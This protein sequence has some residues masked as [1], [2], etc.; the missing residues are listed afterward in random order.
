MTQ[1]K[2]R[3]DWVT[4]LLLALMLAMPAWTVAQSD[5][6]PGLDLLQPTTL[7][8]LLLGTLIARSKLRPLAAQLLGLGYGAAWVALAS[9]SHLPRAAGAGELGEQLVAL[10][11]HIGIWTWSLIQNGVGKDNFMFLLALLVVAW[12]LGFLAAWNTFR[13]ARV[14]RAVLPAGLMILIDLYYY[15]G[16]LELTPFLF[17][18]FAFTLLYLV[19]VH[20]MLREREWRKAWLGYDDDVRGAFLRGGSIVTLV[21]VFAAWAVPKVVP[22]VQ[23]EDLWRQ[24]NRPIRSLEDSFGRMFS[25]LKGE[26]PALTNPFGKSLGF[27]GARELSDQV[28]MDVLVHKSNGSALA[29]YWRAGTYDVYT[30]DGWLGSQRETHVFR[31]SASP[32]STPYL[33]RANVKQTFTTYFK[34]ATL[35]LA[36]AQPV[37]FNRDAEAGVERLAIVAGGSLPAQAPGFVDPSFVYSIDRLQEG[38]AYEV[39]SSLSIADVTTLRAAGSSYPDWIAEHYLQLP[40]NFPQRV[41]DLALQIVTEAGATNAFDQATALERW[42]R[43]N[44]TYDEKIEGPAQGQD[45]VDYVLFESHAGY[46][47]YYA[48]AMVT[49]ARSLG[50]PARLAVGYA[51][52]EFDA[53]SG[54]YRVR[55]RDAHSWVEIYFPNYG[56][57]EFEPTAAQPLISRPIVVEDGTGDADLSPVPELDPAERLSRLGEEE[58]VEPPPS[59]VSPLQQLTRTLPGSVIALLGVLLGVG[60]VFAVVGVYVFENRGLRGLRGARWAFARLVRLATWLRI[61]VRSHQTPYEQAALLNQA[62]PAGQPSIDTIAGDFVRET[63]GRDGGD[64][65]RAR[66]LWR[67]VHWRL[68]WAGVKHRARDA[69]AFRLNLRRLRLPLRRR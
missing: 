31:A 24:F 64:S 66:A 17:L 59:D 13:A 6:A 19:R 2:S 12:L 41:K 29:R 34:N 52:G 8:A 33:Q 27:A 39:I 67:H 25:G 47:D 15:G 43:R 14:L 45:G 44:I 3:L 55:E 46:C 9:L 56:W 54:T 20:Y 60:A 65:A 37:Y 68:W 18:F 5:W 40:D 69:L 51:R 61:D 49:M 53:R 63:Y 50:V 28:L 16:S 38:D 7:V 23:F 58:G 4:L 42:L 10:G 22:A 30:S 57:I 62:A 26:G 35:L 32:L 1:T 21:V 48:S 36:A 11:R